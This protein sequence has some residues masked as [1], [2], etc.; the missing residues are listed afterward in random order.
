M[1]FLIGTLLSVL[2]LLPFTLSTYEMVSYYIERAPQGYRWASF[3]DLWFAAV[4]TVVFWSLQ[5]VFEYSLYPF[6]WRQ[7][8]EKNDPVLRDMRTRKAV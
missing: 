7:C 3:N 1:A 5:K 8:K 6:F 4:T 2:I